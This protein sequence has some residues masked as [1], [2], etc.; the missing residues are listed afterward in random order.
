MWKSGAQ[1]SK[2]NQSLF[3]FL[4]VVCG[5]FFSF[6]HTCI[7]RWGIFPLQYPTSDLHMEG[8]TSNQKR[9]L[10]YKRLWHPGTNC[11]GMSCWALGTTAAATSAFCQI[12]WSNITLS[13]RPKKGSNIKL[14]TVRSVD[15]ILDNQVFISGGTFCWDVF[16]GVFVLGHQFCYTWE[17]GLSLTSSI[18]CKS[19]LNNEDGSITLL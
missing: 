14:P 13:P 5:L 12:K 10:T 11:F 8:H 19:Q 1:W 16:K 17:N 2:H 9:A 15:L 4:C 3:C 7:I 6:L 18:I